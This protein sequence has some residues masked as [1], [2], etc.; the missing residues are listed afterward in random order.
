MNV[1][2]SIP[3]LRP[4]LWAVFLERLVREQG[5]RVDL[6]VCEP[7]DHALA[8]LRELEHK[9]A[10]DPDLSGAFSM[11]RSRQVPVITQKRTRHAASVAWL[12]GAWRDRARRA[13]DVLHLIGEAAYLSTWQGLRF[14]ARH[15]RSTPATLYAAQNIVMRFPPPFPSIE[16]YAYRSIDVAFPITPAAD[17]VLKEKGYRGASRLIPLGVDRTVF[18]PAAPR[19]DSERPVVGFVGV[20][21]PHKGIADLLAAARSA[22]VDLL[23]VG[24]GSLLGDIEREQ[25][26]RPGRIRIEPWVSPDRL[27]RLYAEMDVFCLPSLAHVQHN[28]PGVRVALREQFG[29]VLIEAMSCGVPV[30]AGDVGEIGYVLG[31]AG[32]LFAAGSS[33]ELAATLSR[34]CGDRELRRGLRERGLVRSELFDW[35][36]IAADVATCWRELAG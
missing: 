23:L 16:R 10:G 11:R 14:R 36:R 27:A 1:V 17:L 20:F 4:D 30:V 28:V 35:S 12:P 5:I 9:L 34:I 29:R 32:L 19:A 13:P 25:A 3:D 22:D 8:R 15:W 33:E 24:T 31:D 21:E 26:L 7:S 6:R 2:V 18:A